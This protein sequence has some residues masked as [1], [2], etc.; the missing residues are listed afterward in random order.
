MDTSLSSQ[1]EAWLITV[2]VGLLFLAIVLWKTN[3][4]PAA[5]RGRLR[6]VFFR[7]KIE[8]TSDWRES[9]SSLADPTLTLRKLSCS[10]QL[11]MIERLIQE[12]P[13]FM[14]VLLDAVLSVAIA[15]NGDT[16]RKAL[17]FLDSSSMS[18]V[19][20]VSLAQ[21]I[22]ESKIDAEAKVVAL[23]A[24]CTIVDSASD[25]PHAALV[26]SIAYIVARRLTDNSPEVQGLAVDTL[27][28]IL[29]DRL[30]AMDAAL[31]RRLSVTRGDALQSLIR[32]IDRNSSLMPQASS[33]ARLYDSSTG[34][35]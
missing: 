12:K 23:K 29:R 30:S 20:R 8:G 33:R 3:E 18:L 13:P 31:A 17:R 25:R 21:R 28:G 10:D 16:R 1:V 7:K 9:L 19:G 32:F 22:L 4:G 14:A 27:E 15:T 6:R 26:D 35:H 34:R 2:G 24:L 5:L 11:A